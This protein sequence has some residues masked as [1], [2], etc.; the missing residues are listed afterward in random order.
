V[1]NLVNPI[2]LFELA[3]DPSPSWFL[4]KKGYEEALAHFEVREFARVIDL[5][6]QQ[7]TDFPADGP[8]QA[9]LSLANQFRENPAKF[10]PVWELPGK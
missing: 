10:D 6:S 8:S 4:L 7:L 9:L 2:A 5:L 1:V 3:N